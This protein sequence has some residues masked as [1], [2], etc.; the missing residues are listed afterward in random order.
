M[1]T[2]RNKTISAQQMKALHATFRRAG[3][4]DEARHNCIHS[5]TDGRTNS[6]REL[7][8]D[9]ARQLLASLDGQQQAARSGQQQHLLQ[10]ARTL[11]KNIYSLSMQ[12]SALNKDYPSDTLED[13]RMNIAKINLWA[14]TYTRSRKNVSQ[15][16]VGELRE[17]KK[18]LEALFRKESSVR[19]L[20]GKEPP[21]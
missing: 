13:R 17:V 12:V 3:M 10:E 2:T 16:N 4:D 6:S 20:P 5:F 18:Q 8:F 21:D 9:E 15:M 19:Q 11:L 1:K 14:R 7:T